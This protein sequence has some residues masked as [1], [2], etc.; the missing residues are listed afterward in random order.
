MDQVTTLREPIDA[1][2]LPPQAIECEQSVIGGLL[3]SSQAL[4]RI[5]FLEAH[6]F[7]SQQH[8][9]AYTCIR[10]M[11]EAGRVVDVLTVSEELKAAGDLE[12]VGGQ[13]YLGS[14]ALNTP[15]AANIRRYAEIVRDKAI[16]RNLQ[17][18]AMAIMEA[19][20]EPGAV[21]AE[22]AQQAET[23]MLSVLQADG[24]DEVSFATAIS[25]AMDARDEVTQAL[26]TGF[27]NLDAKLSG[28]GLKPGQLIIV[29]GRSSMGK[30]ALALNIAEA[31]AK[32]KMVAFFTLEMTRRELAQRSIDYHESQIGLNDAL[33]HTMTMLMQVDETSA[34][35]L[36]HIR[37]RLRR[38]KR[39]HG[40]GLVV[41]DYLQ[42][43]KGEGEN[44]TQEVGS[45]S[46]GLKAI[47]KEFAVPVIAV[48]Q[49]N[50][51]VEGRTDKRPMLSDLRESG[52]IENDA[53]V[54]L[55]IYRDDYY[56]PGSPALGLAEVIIRKQRS[57]PV[58]TV[59]MAFNARYTRFTPYYEA[60]PQ[61]A[62]KAGKVA[63][64]NDYKS[65]GE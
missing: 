28:G 62:V 17:V 46:R 63:N 31:V 43:M 15:S 26:S 6:H 41:V 3:L 65:S 52:D 36:G 47:A 30:S 50:R 45:L 57:G 2:R 10:A 13:A 64:F 12:R 44:R 18:H 1:M 40:L 37:M 9:L 8:R 7:Y 33:Q 38:I 24:G 61:P 23:R 14:L 51:G 59:N 21:P 55:M 5:E 58:G 19:S 25:E 29:A 27:P 60:M 48:A 11:V 22:L 4:D 49:I 53:D 35:T 39:K 20:Y 54:V 42:L 32:Q 16:L 56:S 34:V